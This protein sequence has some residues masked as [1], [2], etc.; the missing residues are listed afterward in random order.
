MD[1]V[2]YLVYGPMSLCNVMTWSVSCGVVCLCIRDL[3]IISLRAV[4]KFEIYVMCI[5][6]KCPMRH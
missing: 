1:E 3:E 2:Q 4:Y 5:D 6:C